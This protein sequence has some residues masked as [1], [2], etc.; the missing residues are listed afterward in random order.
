GR[1]RSEAPRG[2][3]RARAFSSA[4]PCHGDEGHGLDFGAAA[5]AAAGSLPYGAC[6]GSAYIRRT[7]L[8]IPVV[9]SPE[10]RDLRLL[11]LAALVAL[12]GCIDLPRD[13]D[14]TLDRIRAARAFRV[15]MIDNAEGDVQAMGLARQLIAR[16]EGRTG[17]EARIER[18]SAA[19]LLPR[20]EAGD[21]DLVLGRFDASS[22]WRK[23]V[24][25][26]TPIARLRPPREGQPYRAATRNGENAWIMVVETE[27]H[28]LR[29]DNG[30]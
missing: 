23:R 29:S 2:N 3:A 26:A 16:L 24:S 10:M 11:A 5:A 20:L 9:G 15:G 6:A 4:V 27:S 17:A 13:P 7:G 8:G 19:I 14:G 28:R 18:A 21:L 30:S 25:L 1:R 12:A 22:P